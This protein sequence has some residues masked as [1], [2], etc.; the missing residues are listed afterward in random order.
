MR[1]FREV[2]LPWS[3]YVTEAA[4]WVAIGRPPVAALDEDFRDIRSS[5]NALS[6][7]LA[8]HF[9]TDGFSKEEFEAIGVELDFD[10]S[11]YRDK[12]LV[13]GNLSGEQY[14]AQSFTKWSPFV[15]NLAVDPGLDLDLAENRWEEQRQTAKAEADWVRTLELPF[16]SIL[17]KARAKVVEALSDGILQAAGWPGH[18]DELG[19]PD[20]A[21]EDGLYYIPESF[22]AMR[23]VD[24]DESSLRHPECTY[25]NVQVATEALFAAFPNPLL[26][27][28]IK[29]VDQYGGI[30][31]SGE[32]APKP[33]GVAPEFKRTRGRPK[34]LSDEQTREIQMSVRQKYAPS[35][36]GESMIAF[37][38][39]QVQSRFGKTVQ[40]TTAQS[41]IADC[42]RR[43]ATN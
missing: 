27:S 34:V 16:V 35:A 3:C 19:E 42:W 40:R 26:S 6:S 36:K 31:V 22:W 43:N 7:S 37:V 14:I 2:E 41:I 11:L 18:P 33:G 9:D 8:F 21:E 25:T 30:L 32:A 39:E 29:S 17:D 20:G 12:R 1:I 5:P 23:F 38:Q 10:F 24:W 13:Y 28:K 15:R 4:Y